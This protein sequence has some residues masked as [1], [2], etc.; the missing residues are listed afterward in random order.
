MDYQ[1]HYNK[2]IQKAHSRILEG[3]C[4]RHHIIPRCMGG[5]DDIDN[6]VNLTPEE[7]FVAHQLLV[8]MYPSNPGLVYAAHTMTA[9]PRRINNKLYGWLKDK[10]P[11]GMLGKS[12][13]LETRRQ[14]SKSRTGIK[15][16]MFGKQH[17]TETKNKMLGPSTPEHRQKLSV[18]AST[19][20]KKP[21]TSATK[22]KISESAKRIQP[23]QCPHCGTIGKPSPMSRWHFDR[24]REK[25]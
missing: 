17:T 4:E 15:N 16:G 10:H 24:C 11:R 6:L 22:H 21:H 8:K 9:G 5:S 25:T 19:T 20:P 7:H 1:R 23:V 2:L 12:H 18:A 3:Y 13:S 14:M